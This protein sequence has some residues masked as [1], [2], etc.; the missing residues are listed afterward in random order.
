[1]NDMTKGAILPHILKF[2]FF[3]FIAGLLQNLY[4]LVDSIILGQ[5]LGKE[6]IAAVGIAMTLNFVVIGFLQGLTQGFSINMAQA[7]GAKD[8]VRF[9]KYFYNSILLSVGLGLLITVVLTLTNGFVLKW[10]NTPDNLFDLANIFL[11]VLYSGTL[12]LLFYNLFSGVLRSIGN[13]FSPILFL[14]LSVVINISVVYIFVALLSGGIWGASLGTVISQTIAS[15]AC[16]FYIKKKYPELTIREEEKVADKQLM[17]KLV[18]QAIPMGLQFSFTGIGVLVLQTFLND[19]STEHIAGFSIA[20][21]IQNIIVF[22]FVALANAIATFIS[23]NYGAKKHDR[24]NQGVKLVV[25]ISLVLSLVCIA[26]IKVF[27]V[28]MVNIFTESPDPLIAEASTTYFNVVTWGYPILALLIVFRSALQGFGFPI[29]AMFAGIIEL[30]MRV[31]V[32]ATLTSSL[33]FL[34]ICLADLATWVVTGVAL[35]V[36]Y[37]YLT[38]TRRKTI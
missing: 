18:T 35:I 5:Y 38:K 28:S 15:I 2:A 13:S 1:M 26:L 32:V 23:Q 14:A 20:V 25:G 4:L 24:I 8:M 27:G 16:F 30:I 10:M 33:G 31:V 29:T 17:K 6:A 7:F 34:A 19:F 12:P 3:V 37:F 21:R 22:V 11:I 9:R 36:A